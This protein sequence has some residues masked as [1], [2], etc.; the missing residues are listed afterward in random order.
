M[1]DAQ[2]TRPAAP[3]PD[4]SDSAIARAKAAKAAT[5][6]YVSRVLVVGGVSGDIRRFVRQAETAN[7]LGCQALLQV[8]SFGF[9]S[10]RLEGDAYLDQVEKYA[11]RFGLV[12]V[13]TPGEDD[14]LD[15]LARIATDGDEGPITLRSHIQCAPHGASWVWGPA[16]VGTVND[17]GLPS[18][19]PRSQAAAQRAL[20]DLDV[21][22]VR[23]SLVGGDVV[24]SP[25]LRLVVYGSPAHGLVS[26]ALPRSGTVSEWAEQTV[27]D[28]TSWS[29]CGSGQSSRQPVA[30][31]VDDFDA[32][33]GHLRQYAAEHEDTFVPPSYVTDDG[34]RLGRW[35]AALR[36]EFDSK[37]LDAARS[38][39]LEAV[40]H[41]RWD[42]F[43][44]ATRA[45]EGEQGSAQAKAR[46]L[47]PLSSLPKPANLSSGEGRTA[48]TNTGRL[49]RPLPFSEW[50][51][52]L[53]GYVAEHGHASP[54]KA[55]VDAEGFKLGRWVCHLRETGRRSRLTAA[56]VEALEVLPGWTWSPK[57]KPATP[58]RAATTPITL[59]QDA[60]G[61]P[62]GILPR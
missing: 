46:A 27:V 17:T 33:L 24:V 44:P 9:Q 40:P 59:P 14:N 25:R 13:W 21:L 53:Q 51:D 7:R 34:F 49:A 38:R 29:F 12:V 4:F 43:E 47:V 10:Q 56:E 37:R 48:R 57:P 18:R 28:L 22:V 26:G 20:S 61:G 39:A 45:A 42:R 16:R 35:L 36:S 5:G 41:W 31:A 6:L 55:F 1:F 62:V 3:S 30:K 54:P 52:R 58:A 50:F 11:R 60:L 32:G 23:G 15:L 2:S 19:P 8:G